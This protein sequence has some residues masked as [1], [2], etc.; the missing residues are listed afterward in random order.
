MTDNDFD[1]AGY[2]VGKHTQG[3]EYDWDAPLD[4]DRHN[5]TIEPA[6]SIPQPSSG[7]WGDTPMYLEDIAEWPEAD[8]E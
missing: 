6:T 3:A 4:P 1:W 2:P 5:H 8:C 7:A